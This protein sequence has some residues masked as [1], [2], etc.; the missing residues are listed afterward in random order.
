MRIPLRGRK[1]RQLVHDRAGG[2]CFY[3]GTK[4]TLLTIDHRVPLCRGG[5]YSITN[6]VGC[7]SRCNRM[8]GSR[9]EADFRANVL[10]G[11]LDEKKTPRQT[12][13]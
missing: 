5:K 7:C 4:K 6:L 11:I 3:C 12:G 9:S 8:K 13:D 1:L 10:P 2:V